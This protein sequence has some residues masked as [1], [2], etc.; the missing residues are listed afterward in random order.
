MF[1]ELLLRK[2][3]RKASNLEVIEAVDYTESRVSN[4]YL[5]EDDKFI[6]TFRKSIIPT[7]VVPIAVESRCYDG[8]QI[9]LIDFDNADI[10]VIQSELETLPEKFREGDYYVFETTKGHYT[11]VN[12]TKWTYEELLELL[13]LLTCDKKLIPMLE[14]LPTKSLSMRISSK[15]YKLKGKIVHSERPEVIQTYGYPRKK[16]KYSNAHYR[17]FRQYFNGILKENED[18]SDQSNDINIKTY[19]CNKAEDKI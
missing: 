6:Y 5:F 12:F 3:L 11:V 4:T 2:E 17:L 1:E 19:V 14:K 8:R 18:Y 15:E 7:V 13:K 9:G 10:N 16:R